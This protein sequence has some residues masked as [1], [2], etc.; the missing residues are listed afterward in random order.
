MEKRIRVVWVLSLVSALLVI[1]VQLYWLYNQYQFVLNGY[2]EELAQK[3]YSAGE[4]EYAMRKGKGQYSYIMNTKISNIADSGALED[5]KHLSFAY[6]Q[7]DAQQNNEADSVLT[8]SIRKTILLQAQHLLDSVNTDVK[9]AVE[10]PF[11]LSGLSLW[12]DTDMSVDSIQHFVTVALTNNIT[13]FRE[14]AFDSILVAELS[15]NTFEIHPWAVGD[16]IYRSSWKRQGSILSPRLEVAYAYS[17]FQRLGIVVNIPIKSQPLFARMAVQLLLAF[18]LILLL[19]GCLV[20]QIRT[21]LKQKKI[22]EMRQNFVNTMIH[23]L[24]RPVQTLKTFVAYLGDKE[25]RSNEV[26]TA[27]VIQD[28]MF[29]LDNLSAYLAKLKDMLRADS[30]QTPLNLVRFDLEE[31]TDKVIRL[32]DVPQGKTVTFSKSFFMDSPLIE[33]DPIHLA[34]VLNNLIEN[35]IK[36]SN[37]KVHIDIKA[38]RTG[39]EL[40]LAISDDGIGI[41]LF[42]QEKVF[43]KFYRGANLPDSTIPGLGLGLSY[44]KLISEAH[45]GKVSLHSNVGCGTIIT[46][47]IPQ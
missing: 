13:P 25:M 42:E 11:S 14:A 26:I 21:I 43:A 12:I 9:R 5:S 15:G 40:L 46:L 38:T 41:P 28:S 23:E 24:K 29:E 39:R 20:F 31:L 34:N 6:I 36:Y 47:S 33:A 30:D 27:Q 3:V 2:S 8:D 32:I 37:T 45:H 35:A 10:Q 7:T 1:A 22:G 17:P 44:V 19:I 18:G 4:E 16:T